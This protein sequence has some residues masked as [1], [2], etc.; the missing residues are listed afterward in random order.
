MRLKAEAVFELW[1][2]DEQPQLAIV[3][4]YRGEYKAIS[5]I[6]DEHPEILE[7]AHQDLEQLSKAT[8]KRGRKAE[9]TSENLLRAVIVMQREGWDY[10]EATVRI[11]ESNMLQNFCRLRREANAEF[12]SVKQ[13][14]WRNSARDVGTDEPRPGAGRRDGR[15]GFNRSRANRYH[16]DGV[17]YPL[18]D[19]LQPSP[20][21]LPRHRPGNQTC[22]E[23]TPF[24]PPMAF[25]REQDQEY[26]LLHRT[27]FE[28]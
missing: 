2:D 12:H 20:G 23:D 1:A 4:E 10:R 14:V 28:Q 5:G 22:D 13:G 15:G 24:W 25:S 9:F 8:T 21:L 18:A 11:A 19:R 26:G 3:S 6:L 16:G 7:M 27:I 17:Q